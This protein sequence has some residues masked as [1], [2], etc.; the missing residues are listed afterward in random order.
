MKKLLMIAM[1]TLSTI[2]SCKKDENK[3]I[4]STKP[5]ITISVAPT[6]IAINTKTN[7]TITATKA[8][9]A[10]LTIAIEVDKADV[11]TVPT[12]VIIKKGEKT[13]TFEGSA[14]AEGTATITISCAEATI[15]S[16]TAIVKVVK[17]VAEP[18]R[19]TSDAP[20]LTFSTASED[21]SIDI[22][23]TLTK[24][25]SGNIELEVNYNFDK[26]NWINTD[27]FP[28]GVTWSEYPIIFPAGETTHTFSIW[29]A[30]G[31]AGTLPL[32]LI[33]ILGPGAKGVEFEP[34]EY[35]F[36]VTK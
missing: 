27:G 2:V 7:F 22:N 36:V 20:K 8:I 14:K 34:I 33:S 4:V 1:V 21:I 6:E 9:E 13:A 28:T 26:Y 31:N 25:V 32:K 35:D 10:D 19:L 17:E 30:Q 24:A 18:V 23:L 16:A 11:L 15:T 5:S 3:P 29:V 12:S